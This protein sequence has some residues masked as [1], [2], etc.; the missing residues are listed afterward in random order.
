MPRA[1]RH[2]TVKAL[3][4]HHRNVVTV[5]R[6]LRYVTGRIITT[7]H[8]VSMFF[9]ALTKTAFKFIEYA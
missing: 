7:A 2:R 9:P 4:L 5:C 3:S 8:L 1:Y 6:T